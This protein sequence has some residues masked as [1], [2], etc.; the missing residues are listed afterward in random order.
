MKKTLEGTVVSVGMKSTIVVE[1]TKRVAHPKYK[2]LIKRSKKF[3]A[4][5]NGQEVSVG[6]KVTIVE[7][8]PIAKTVHF[9]VSK[10]HQKI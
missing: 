10:V 4:A 3:K 2:K 1:V 8:K 7:T 9:M 5:L 6:D